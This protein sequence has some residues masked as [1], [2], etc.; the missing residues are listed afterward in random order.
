MDEHHNKVIKLFERHRRGDQFHFD[1]GEEGGKMIISPDGF[2]YVSFHFSN[3][4]EAAQHEQEE[5]T[6]AQKRSYIFKI[7]EHHKD[8]A[9]V[10]HYHVPGERLEEFL[11]SLPQRPGTLL[12]IKPFIP[13]TTA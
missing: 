5:L 1:V 12:E 11:E 6:L 13:N 3:A 8:T 4:Q 7:L 2:H 9:R 10:N